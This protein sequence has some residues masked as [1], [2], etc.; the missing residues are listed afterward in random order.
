MAIFSNFINQGVTNH[1]K[2]KNVKDISGW[3]LVRT[4]NKHNTRQE[5]TNMV[6]QRLKIISRAL[7]EVQSNFPDSMQFIE[8]CIEQGCLKENISVD[9]VIFLFTSL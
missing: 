3:G 6:K 9:E 2:N 7:E 8:D 4:S 5:K 1:S